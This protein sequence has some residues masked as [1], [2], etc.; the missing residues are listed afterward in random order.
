MLAFAW[1]SVASTAAQAG[2]SERLSPD[3][4]VDRWGTAEGLQQ[5][6]VSAVSLD[7]HGDLW[8]GTFAGLHRFT[9]TGFVPVVLPPEQQATL[10]RVTSLL[11]DTGG[12][13]VGIQGAGIYWFDGVSLTRNVQPEALYNSHVRSLRRGRDGSLLVATEEEG[14]WRRSKTE[15][16]TQ[17]FA[18]P[19]A[20]VVELDDGTMF[21]ASNHD[22]I[23]RSS[24][25][26]AVI[27]SFAQAIYGLT[28]DPGGNV[29]IQ[30][31]RG[32][33]ILTAESPRELVEVPWK[34]PFPYGTR[35]AVDTKGH[36]WLASP[37]AVV[38]VGMWRTTIEAFQQGEITDFKV[39]P[40]EASPRTLFVDRTGQRWV[41]TI[42]GG[43]VR[44]SEQLYTKFDLPDGLGRDSLGPIVGSG[45]EVWAA[46]GCSW[47]VRLSADGVEEA[48]DI[49]VDAPA[50]K[51]CIRGMALDGNG[52]VWF[53]WA[54]A[55]YRPTEESWTQV[56]PAG[57]P[58]SPM[59][60]VHTLDFDTKGR[61]WAGTTT[62]RTLRMDEEGSLND[63]AMP[64]GAGASLSF[65]FVDD[66]TYVGTTDGLVVMEE[67]LEPVFYGPEDGLPYGPIRDIAVDPSGVVWMVSYGG[68]LGWLDGN[69]TGRFG[70]DIVGMPDGFLS[71]VVPDQDGG[72]WL[73][74]N[75]GLHYLRGTE[76][77]MARGTERPSL[78]SVR[79][80]I[81][82]AN[83]WN[84]PAHWLSPQG[85]LWAVTLNQIVRFP[86]AVDREPALA[87]MPRI[88]EVRAR[89]ALFSMPSEVVTI[90]S[91]LGRTIDVVF[92]TP[93]LGPDH[94]PSYS[95][96]LTSELEP[97][98]PW[99]QPGP[100]SQ[101]HFALLAPGSYTFEVQAMSQLAVS[102]GVTT[103]RIEIPRVWH[104]Q[105]GIWVGLFGFIP[106]LASIFGGM[107]LFI[108][109]GRNRLL[110][111]ENR[112]RRAAEDRAHLRQ[113]QYRQLFEA[114]GHGLL[115]FSPEG[116]CTDANSEAE[117]I[118]RVQ[119][120]D[121]V[122]MDRNSLGLDKEDL[123]RVHCRRTD[124][125]LFPARVATS[126]H[127]EGGQNRL[128][129]SVVD[130]SELL[131]AREAERHLRGQLES[132]RRIESLGRLAGGVAHDMNNL[133]AAIIGNAELM[134]DDNLDQT[135]KE[136]R[137]PDLAIGL[138][139]ILDSSARGARLIE[140]LMSMGRRDS[141]PPSD[142][143]IDETLSAMESM[144]RR[145]VRTDIDLRMDVRTGL[146]V[147][148]TKAA[149]EQVVLNLVMNASDAIQQGGRID[150]FAVVG[151]SERHVELTV[152]DTGTGISTAILGNIFE[153]FVTSKSQGEGTGLGLATVRDIVNT[154]GG[155]VAVEST[156]GLG[157][158]FTVTLP[159]GPLAVEAPNQEDHQP[160]EISHSGVQVLVVDDNHALRRTIYSTL[161][162]QGYSVIDF[163]DP[164]EA[165]DWTRRNRPKLDVL[166]SDVVMP[167]LDGRTFADRLR[168]D[169]QTLPVLFISGYT[170]DVVVRHG[171]HLREALLRKPFT[172]EA[173]LA[174]LAAILRV[175]R[176][177]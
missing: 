86:L 46:A 162:G 127:M 129:F 80:D 126:Q 33:W 29:W 108:V 113:H 91:R 147:R 58:F 73:H 139:E 8:V 158:S 50:K 118:F 152:R 23:V 60:E 167:G 135:T 39:V 24:G 79:F 85:M 34:H 14:V 121:L 89:D 35:P 38:D 74:G 61:L 69:T 32:V 68:G 94:R 52:E 1:F 166:I 143:S 70:T 137:D 117:R 168:E 122:G 144:L 42:G 47:L 9:G 72:L 31:A 37:N 120:K 3:V 109:G 27:T 20:D 4:R 145:V 2:T 163:G 92:T 11:A 41:G 107:R 64:V 19:A 116:K 149:L 148:A 56:H 110:K 36:V 159:A 77:D 43:L 44:I 105:P 142:I 48:R 97:N 5:A 146:G 25:G 22:L 169:Y 161:S 62:G 114:A 141:T 93:P 154:L 128:L 124:G 53:G 103:M 18:A 125:S 59:S 66:V 176:S 101:A 87:S 130:L 40:T 104:E 30:G 81:G 57:E 95:Y 171:L 54:G 99:S 173:I 153:P 49:Q 115:L 76:L 13:W 67:G 131:E 111:E 175:A 160:D 140:Q 26:E 172:R 17:E 63:I 100:K 98:P 78:V 150:V 28:A 6:T 170:G 51:F 136:A 55:L 164:V 10:A 119:G 133:L 112:Q 102:S 174:S 45:N 96:R 138:A 132:A 16:W 65:E 84:R 106:L 83:G 165:L 90:P 15:A 155:S 12:Q 151:P 7:E 21:I 134:Q 71:T 156:I 88:V 157:S 177:A 123:H 82:G 75:Q